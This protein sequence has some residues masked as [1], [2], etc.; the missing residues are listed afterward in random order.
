MVY[1]EDEV[2]KCLKENEEY[3][4]REIY[5][6]MME[7]KNVQILSDSVHLSRDNKSVKYRVVSIKDKFIHKQ[8]DDSYRTYLIP[9]AETKIIEIVRV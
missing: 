2:P 7:N 6:F 5:L 3:T 1:Y 9:N 4:S 8:A